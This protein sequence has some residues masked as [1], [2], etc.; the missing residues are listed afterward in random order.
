ML[1]ASGQPIRE[2]LA[3]STGRSLTT[4]VVL[5]LLVSA[6]C[7]PQEPSP[8]KP[9]NIVLVV[10][11]T[12][13]RDHLGAYGYHKPTSPVLDRLARDGLLFQKAY[14]QAP[15]TY[16]STASLFTGQ[17]VPLRWIV[18]KE[19][20]IPDLFFGMQ[21]GHAK[22]PILLD[23]NLTLAE[24]LRDLGYATYGLFTN[25]HHHER[26]GFWQGFE[27]PVYMR[28]ETPQNPYAPADEVCDQFIDDMQNHTGGAPIYAYVHFMDVHHPYMPPERFRGLS[29]RTP[30]RDRY[31]SRFDPVDVTEADIA[32]MEELY[33]GEIRF[34]DE[35]IG[36]MVGCLTRL[37]LWKN[38][39]LVVASDHGEEFLDHGKFGHGHTME[40]ELLRVPLIMA[41]GGLRQG[42]GDS[43]RVLARNLDIPATILDLVSGEES[44]EFEGASLLAD[45]GS[46][47]HG[48]E[49]MSV[50]W[51]LELRSVTTDRWHFIAKGDGEVKLYDNRL[52]P[53][54][55]MDVALA[56]PTVIEKFKARVTSL[57]ESIRE[58]RSAARRAAGDLPAEVE[59]DAVVEQLKQLGYIDGGDGG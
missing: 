3:M 34:V 19:G 33:D 16:N 18:K 28:G 8:Q 56:H 46:P 30:G 13:R 27:S 17:L 55:L 40:T 48:E 26:S 21:A 15:Q 1:E 54:G 58:M 25:P 11:D 50:A 31:A 20:P 57:E 7:A 36:R 4:G 35:Q 49:E 45:G 38:T 22:V 23:E 39:V 14:S 41:G 10:I 42:A 47:S 29:G 9:P 6:G 12:L 53:A 37:G 44:T 5:T 52:D 51:H 59:T 24:A 2:P 32:Y 43:S